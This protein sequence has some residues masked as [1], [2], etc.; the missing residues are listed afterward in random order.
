MEVA[1]YCFYGLFGFWKEG[2]VGEVVILKFGFD[3][4][5]FRHAFLVTMIPFLVLRKSKS[6]LTTLFSC[7]CS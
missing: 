3:G 4:F 2:E 1:Y 7:L 5:E 6:A